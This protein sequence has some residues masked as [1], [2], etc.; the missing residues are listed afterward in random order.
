LKLH[1]I[2]VLLGILTLALN[3][4]LTLHLFRSH[5]SGNYKETLERNELITFRLTREH[6]AEGVTTAAVPY[7]DTVPLE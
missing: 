1:Y 4:A 6:N 7:E 3:L 2:Y 5:K